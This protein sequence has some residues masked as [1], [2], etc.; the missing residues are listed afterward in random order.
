MN[1]NTVT[2][3]NM[4]PL[5]QG[6]VCNAKYKLLCMHVTQIFCEMMLRTCRAVPSHQCLHRANAKKSVCA[7]DCMCP[8]TLQ[9]VFSIQPYCQPVCRACGVWTKLCALKGEQI[10]SGKHAS[11]K[12]RWI[13]SGTFAAEYF[14]FF[15]FFR[16]REAFF[17]FIFKHQHHLPLSG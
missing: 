8:V 3:D 4:S 12:E 6:C 14:L 16:K 17:D 7:N 10:L 1:C 2:Q 5:A 9:T 15:F 13:S 11:D